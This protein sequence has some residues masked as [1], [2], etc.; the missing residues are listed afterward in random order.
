MEES[1]KI[2]K[3]SEIAVEDKWAIEDLY[4][5]DDAWEGTLAT[6]EADKELLVAFAGKLSESG[7][8]LYDFLYLSEMTNVKARRLANYGMRKADE[9]TRESKYQA[10]T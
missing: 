2:K 8:T 10:M 7:K 9:D 6:L 4:P 1:T 3:R 5:S